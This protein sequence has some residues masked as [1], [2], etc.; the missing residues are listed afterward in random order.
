MKRLRR[1]KLIALT[2]I[3]IMFLNMFSPFI[4]IFNLE[5]Q[6]NSSGN[7]EIVNIPQNAILLKRSSD[8]TSA[9]N[10]KIF[11]M[12]IAITGDIYVWSIDLKF[13]YD[14]SKI[15]P[16]RSNG[17]QATTMAQF[18]SIDGHWSRSTAVD[19]FDKSASTFRLQAT[20]GQ[21]AINPKAYMEDEGLDD[22]ETYTKYNG[23]MKVYKLYF[24]L[25]DENLTEE[26]LTTDLFNL[27]PL[28]NVLPTGLSY[29]YSADNTED[30][31]ALYSFDSEILGF[32]NFVEGKNS[33]IKNVTLKTLPSKVNYIHNEDIDLT[34]GELTVEL[35]DGSTKTVSMTDPEVTLVSS[36]NADKTKQEVQITYYGRQI[37]FTIYVSDP[38]ESLSFIKQPTNL[39]Y[40]YQENIKPDGAIIKVVKKSGELKAITLPDSSV[41]MIGNVIADLSDSGNS[42]V[43]GTGADGNPA[44]IQTVTL[45][46]DGKQ[47]QYTITVNQ[48]IQS[49]R[50]GTLPKTTYNYGENLALEHGTIIVTTDNGDIT[51]PLTDSSI[52][53]TELDGSTYNSKKLGTRDVLVDYMGQTT[54]FSVTINDYVEKLTVNGPTKKEYDAGEALDLAGTE[55]IPLTASG[56]TQAAV[57]VTEDM[58]TTTYDPNKLGIQLI[59]LKYSGLEGS[60][61]VTVNDIT[62]SI[63]VT[64]PINFVS[65]FG[66][67]LDLSNVE[68]IINMISGSTIKGGNVNQSMISEFNKNQLGNQTVT[69]TY[70]GKTDTFNVEVIE[71]VSSIAV[72]TTPKT[73]YK[74]GENLNV[75]NGVI[76]VTYTSGKT[77]DI[78]MTTDKVSG[79]NKKQLGNQTLTVTYAGKTTAYAINVEDYVKELQI[80]PPT[81]SKVIKGQNLDLTGAK[82]KEI[83]ASGALTTEIDVTESM[84]K[85]PFDNTKLGKQTLVVEYSGKTA[86]FDVTVTNEIV[87][88]VLDKSEGKTIYKVDEPLDVTKIKLDV[89]RE[90][91]DVEQIILPDSKVTVTGFDSSLP[92]NSQIVTITYEG[93]KVTYNIEIKDYVKDYEVTIPK[94]TYIKGEQFS[95]DG[96]YIVEKLA[97]G[98]TGN[99]IALTDS[100]VTVANIDTTKVGIQ[101]LNITYAGIQKAIN[102]EVTNKA[103]NMIL[104]TKGKLI[105]KV[106]EPLDLSGFELHVTREDG[107]TYKVDVTP[108]MVTGFDSSQP[109]D[110]Q[111]LTVKYEGLAKTFQIKI[112]D[113][114]K[115][116]K[117]TKPQKETYKIGEQIDLTDGYLVEKYAS[118]KISSPI[119]LDDSNVVIKGFDTKTE[120]T[121]TITVEYTVEGKKLTDTYQILVVDK[122]QEAN[123]VSLPE[124]LEYKYGEPLNL[125]GGQ[126]EAKKE[127]GKTEKIELTDSKVKVTGYNA[128]KLGKQELTVTY[129]GLEKTF[130]F[131]VE[132]KDYVTG[133]KITNPT[134]TTYKYGEDLSLTGA[135]VSE[136]MASGAVKNT[137]AI[138]GSMISKFDSKKPGKQTITVSY[139]EFTK[140]FTVT[141]E[142]EVKPTEPTIPTTPV[143]PSE[144][145]TKP[146]ES[147]PTS[148]TES[149]SSN[150]VASKPSS[151]STQSPINSVENN[152]EV[153]KEEP[154]VEEP[155]NKEP[156]Q[157]P[158]QKPVQRPQ[159]QKPTETLGVKDEKDTVKSNKQIVSIIGI[160]GSII[161]LILLFFRRNVKIYVE[162]DGEFVLGG[163]DKLNKKHLELDIDKYLD[164]ETYQN[165]V[166]IHLSE[167]ASEKLDGKEIEI[168]HR[169]QKK[170]YKI[171]YDD[172][173]YE[174]IIK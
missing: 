136:V 170:K 84:L 69:V 39:S 101:T 104:D 130:K 63:K 142:E 165:K 148:P 164:G 57:P 98:N 99:T 89:T 14:S 171:T 134:K 156:E 137:T 149:T 22:D 77:E 85:T 68:F 72:K 113:Y 106:G 10:G 138:T 15:V 123:L 32:D 29:G 153:E 173:A 140:Q 93:K 92:T 55:I 6:A 20:S 94:K 150:Q 73:T 28:P 71:A 16:G 24:K 109:A 127:S 66:Q 111:M 79:Y 42:T 23:Y 35:K 44:G 40:A 26:D 124:K 59:K 5:S 9:K 135:T 87:Q 81:N 60:F 47:L 17:A 38:T 43:L 146:T 25:V 107:Q 117:V 34:G 120:G 19:K 65:I 139:A 62:E 70:Q 129:E 172:K 112:N 74:Y 50:M 141:V 64:A 167:A 147:R 82:V 49:I 80:T 36:K 114:V 159:E 83:M 122:L 131:E 116:I 3:L 53:I 41:T 166:K 88:I 91:G 169:G 158:V 100:R 152:D 37:K 13:T 168:K 145:A 8:I 18:S 155:E 126:I 160:I 125:K 58:L 161:L 75:E 144:P 51:I 102:I 174:I 78:P 33:S 132:V 4:N 143:K 115:E 67:D 103:V 110:R 154:S 2:L 96:S 12:D 46:Y 7:S 52:K 27:E 105:Y 157:Q 90:N 118:G 108:S 133:I 97:S 119:K 151:D 95:L 76:E 31:S 1:S 61:K 163:L 121:K 48:A 11:T 162:E 21:T 54:K 86:S 128:K 30:G 45:E 56:V